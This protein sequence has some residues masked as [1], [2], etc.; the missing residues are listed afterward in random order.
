MD[1]DIPNRLYWTKDAFKYN[2]SI[3]AG[4][5]QVGV[6]K[7]ASLNRSVKASLLGKNYV[8]EK[9]GFIKKKIN[10][11]DL[12]DRKEVGTIRFKSLSSKA[13]ITLFSTE[14]SD[15]YLW[16]FKNSFSRRWMMFNHTGD[17]LLSGKSR[18]EGYAE[19]NTEKDGVLL[20]S[21]LVIRNLF[22]MQGYG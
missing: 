5:E 7:D 10:V 6:I 20:L 19:Y 13:L 12:T 3:F 22:A 16:K 11:F 4:S 2:H 15:R 14:K 8:F 18:K 9:S 17:L 21:A 1:S